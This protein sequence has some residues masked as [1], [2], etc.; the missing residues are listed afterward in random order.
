MAQLTFDLGRPPAFGRDDF[1]VAPSNAE[2]VAWLERWPDWPAPGLALYGP[3]GCGKSHLLAAFA[4]AQDGLVMPAAALTV[5]AVPALVEAHRVVLLDDLEA[6]AEPAALF[7]LYNLARESGHF[8]VVAGRQ[9]PARL[10]LG[11]A[12]LAS[13]LATLPVVAIGAPDDA[14]LAAVIVKLFADCQLKVGV[15]VVRYLVG[16]IE[17][18][19]AAAADVVAA[20]DRASLAEARPVTVPLAR[21]VLGE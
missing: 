16:R 17:R 19:F 1:L 18:S 20:L 14:L 10:S 4:A 7:H 21:R 13:R 9:P 5:A 8:V 12:D 11:L 15:D 3:A 2:A 6:L